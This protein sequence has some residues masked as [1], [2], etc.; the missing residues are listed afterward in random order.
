MSSSLVMSEVFLLGSA[1]LLL[2]GTYLCWNAPRARMSVEEHEKDGK[3]TEEQMRRRIR[4]LAWS[5]PAVVT[6]GVVFLAIGLLR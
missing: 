3:I 4:F 1:L 5:G 2:L 6:V